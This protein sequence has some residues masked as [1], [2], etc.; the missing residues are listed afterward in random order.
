M[1]SNKV[2]GLILLSA[3]VMVALSFASLDLNTTKKK[4]SPKRAARFYS[5]VQEA[6]VR[7]R[8]PFGTA[9][10]LTLPTVLQGDVVEITLTVAN[11]SDA[12]LELKNPKSCCGT[13]V[14]AMSPLIPPGEE[15]RVRAIIMTDKWGGDTLKG[16]V[17]AETSDPK[18]PLLRLDT[19]LEVTRFATLSSHKI[20]LA[21]PGES[22]LTGTSTVT[23]TKAH[24]FNILGI[25]AKKG[26]HITFDVEEIHDKA[27]TRYLVQV[28]NT[29][30]RAGVYRDTL[31]LQTDNPLRPE[32]RIRVEGHIE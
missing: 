32:L 29:L 31:F 4:A 24:P 5:G 21:G 18:R 10:A 20:I 23:P 14:T 9:T 22:P 6:P 26:L 16:V 28:S 11:P 27:G 7:V 13:L 15:G 30:K 12:P 8:V 3:A 1:R 17:Q 25:K 19:T 2:I